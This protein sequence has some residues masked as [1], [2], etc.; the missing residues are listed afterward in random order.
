MAEFDRT[1]VLSE[2][3]KDML[4][5]YWWN[6]NRRGDCDELDSAVLWMHILFDVDSSS[7]GMV[8]ISNA[9]STACR[10]HTHPGR[11]GPGASPIPS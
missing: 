7:D 3:K 10:C 4:L 5:L 6:S 8:S 1:R 2:R 9:Y 11:H